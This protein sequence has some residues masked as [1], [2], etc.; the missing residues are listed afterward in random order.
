MK[1][2]LFFIALLAVIFPATSHAQ[3]LFSEVAW[4]GSDTNPA[5]EWIELYNF[6]NTPTDLAGWTL[7][8]QDGVININL[9]GVLPPHGVGVL[10]QG[11]DSSVPGV[12][13]LLVYQGEMNDNGTT[14]TIKDSAGTTADQTP[15]GTNWTGIGGLNVTPQ[16][17]FSAYP[18]G[19][20]DNR[21]TDTRTRKSSSE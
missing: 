21:R 19:H 20:L 4:M 6:S 8:S 3:V 17:D 13:A 18:H 16:E 12:T 11:S 10:E 15:G 5:H 2:R 7:T 1:Y 14:L 9:S